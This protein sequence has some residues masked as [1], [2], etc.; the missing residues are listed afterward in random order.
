[1]TR[2]FRVGSVNFFDESSA[3]AHIQFAND[4]PQHSI[5][6]FDQDFIGNG[7]LSILKLGYF[8]YI[9]S[10]Y[11]SLCCKDQYIVESYSPHRFSRC[12]GF[13]RDIFR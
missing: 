4:F 11:L 3:R 6:D 1:M 2:Y 7:R 8:T 9:H 13:H 10:G 12:F 5:E